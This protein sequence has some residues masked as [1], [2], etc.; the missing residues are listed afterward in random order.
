LKK[1]TTASAQAKR[2]EDER[3]K[4]DSGNEMDEDDEERMDLD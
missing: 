2:Q 3:N 4:G 1:I